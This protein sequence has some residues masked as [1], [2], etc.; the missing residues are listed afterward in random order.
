MERRR[1][2]RQLLLAGA[3]PL[4]PRLA[5]SRQQQDDK[6]GFTIHSDVRLVVL[7]VSVKDHSGGFVSGLIKDNFTVFE[8]GV[9]Q[10]ITV[11][12]HED[13][14]VTAGI[15]VDESQSMLPKR[16]DVIAAAEALIAESNSKDEIF[17]L[18]FNEYVRRGLPSGQLF[19]DDLDQLGAALYRGYPAGRTALYD[20]VIA[21]LEQLGQGQR[22][23]KALIVI[24]DGGDNASEHHR[25]DLLEKLDRSSATV[26]TVGVYDAGDQDRSPGILK[27]MAGVSGG[28]AFFPESLSD[29]TG[30]CKSIAKEIR[31]RY[32]VGYIPKATNGGPLRHVHVAVSAPEHG[33]M[34]AQARSRY[35]YEEPPKPGSK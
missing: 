22:D 27:Y 21:G 12:A 10:P 5:S 35:W 3:L 7:D 26:Y 8:N 6:L 31:T 18:N 13:L 33:K 32:T 4:L 28:A 11:F 24:S 34:T 16:K 2:L 15:L 20:A 30:V 29:L 19:S 17:V 14:P 23:K 1:A 25:R 9:T